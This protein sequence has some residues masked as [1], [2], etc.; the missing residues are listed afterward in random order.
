MFDDSLKFKKS[1]NFKKV[2]MSKR[3]E[4][5]NDEAIQMQAMFIQYSQRSSIRFTYP[6]GLGTLKDRRQLYVFK[7]YAVESL[8]NT[9][10]KVGKMRFDM[11]SIVCLCLFE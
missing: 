6:K 2:T 5:S 3:I 10:L 9:T 8:H 4:A 7:D 1:E 11:D